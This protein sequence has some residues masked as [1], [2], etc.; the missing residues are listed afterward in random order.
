M[1]KQLSEK[2]KTNTPV[3]VTALPPSLTGQK[4]PTIDSSVISSKSLSKWRRSRSNTSKLHVKLTKLF[5]THKTECSVIWRDSS[6]A[7]LEGWDQMFKHLQTKQTIKVEVKPVIILLLQSSLKRLKQRLSAKLMLCKPRSLTSK[8]N[9]W[10]WRQVEVAVVP[11][12]DL[13]L[14]EQVLIHL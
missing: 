13:S 8:T 4:R 2:L 11:P 3:L 1:I 6:Q 9:S 5:K 12:W 10:E 7:Q 14:R